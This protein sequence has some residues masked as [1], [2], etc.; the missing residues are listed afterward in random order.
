MVN[1]TEFEAAETEQAEEPVEATEP[2]DAAEAA[3]AAAPADA[4]T[5]A[6][7][8]AADGKPLIVSLA[9]LTPEERHR[10]TARLVFLAPD[11]PPVQPR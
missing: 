2:A 3:E 6:P 8:L 10:A 5:D 4:S 11:V 9:E 7:T 1:E